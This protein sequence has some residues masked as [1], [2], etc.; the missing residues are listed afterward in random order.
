M[1][2]R[3][4]DPRRKTRGKRAFAPGVSRLSELSKLT[5]IHPD[6]NLSVHTHVSATPGLSFLLCKEC[7]FPGFGLM[8]IILFKKIDNTAT[9]KARIDF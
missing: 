1:S 9:Q 3:F 7:W 2:G 6:L 8:F 5:V 4:A